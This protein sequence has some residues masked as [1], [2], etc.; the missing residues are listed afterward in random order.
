MNTM[1]AMGII[2]KLELRPHPEGGH[3][4]QVF[5]DTVSV[6]LNDSSNRTR[7]AITDIYFLLAGGEKSRFHRVKQTEIW[8]FYTGAP[9]FLY[10]LSEDLQSLEII[11]LGKDLNF[12][13]TVKANHWQAASTTGDFSLVGC[14]VAPGFEFEDFSLMSESGDLAE[15]V[16]KKYPNLAHLI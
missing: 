2:E 13:H 10:D 7:S 6:N 5:K 1:S 3:Y 15:L 8:N 11:E 9:L 12:K 14:M 16:S 4:K